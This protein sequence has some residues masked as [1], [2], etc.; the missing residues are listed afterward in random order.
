MTGII[1][2]PDLGTELVDR[3][4]VFTVDAADTRLIECNCPRKLGNGCGGID[5]NKLPQEHRAFELRCKEMGN[6]FIRQQKARGYEW[7]SDLVVH[8][9]FQSYDFA[10]TMQDADSGQW[11]NMRRSKEDG[12]EHPEALLPMVFERFMHLADYVVVGKFLFKDT[13][14]D[15]EAPVGN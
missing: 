2:A 13:M 6:R 14:T 1:V 3:S 9:P 12:M 5:L 8:G 10:N 11:R 7:V 4:G 15:L